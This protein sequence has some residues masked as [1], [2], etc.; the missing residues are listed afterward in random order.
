MLR[1]MRYEWNFTLA[2]GS[3]WQGKATQSLPSPLWSGLS[4]SRH[5][6]P[7]ATPY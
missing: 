3:I 6:R 2:E 1:Y 4:R 5:A 7:P